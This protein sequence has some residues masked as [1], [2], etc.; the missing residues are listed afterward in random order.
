MLLLMER[1]SAQAGT[2]P[3]GGVLGSKALFQEVAALL[4]DRIFSHELAPGT[5]IDEKILA[6]EYGISRTPMREALKVLAGEGLVILKPRRGCQVVQVSGRDIKEIFPVMALL[7]GQCAYEAMAKITLQ[8]IQRL[9]A[10]HE[11]IRVYTAQNDRR[12]WL[13]ADH[14]F[15]MMLYEI[16]GNRWLLQLIQDMRRVIR[17]IRYHFLLLDGR[18]G[19]SLEEHRN[20][21]L[22][23]YAREP[24]TVKECVAH[25]LL[26][27]GDALAAL[28]PALS[29]QK[30][31]LDD[32]L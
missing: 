13:E 20:I 32:S 14:E 3:V 28:H 6:K 12:G 25:H 5:W 2:S 23:I 9:D 29:A 11:K 8:D 10:L 15:H 7:E 21:M 24:A 1:T 19:E 4:R 31:V 27:C 22:A 16:S 26:C 30:S 18:L 17:L